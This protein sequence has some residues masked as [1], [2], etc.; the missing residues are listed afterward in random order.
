MQFVWFLERLFVKFHTKVS[1]ASQSIAKQAVKID[2][3][4]INTFNGYY[5]KYQSLYLVSPSIK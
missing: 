4:Q 1:C 5:F 2:E 3:R